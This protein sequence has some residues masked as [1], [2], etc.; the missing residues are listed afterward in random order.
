MEVNIGGPR[1]FFFLLFLSSYACN[2]G[3]SPC[4]HPCTCTCMSLACCSRWRSCRSGS[5]LKSTH[6]HLK[7]NGSKT[8]S[9]GAPMKRLRLN[10]GKSKAKWFSTRGSTLQVLW[11]AG[12]KVAKLDDCLFVFYLPAIKKNEKRNKV[13][14][15]ANL[16]IQAID[17]F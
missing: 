4:S 6:P 1:F 13:H 8:F 9:R 15:R 7:E 14:H 17:V 10:R 11:A 5:V 16:L 2:R 12:I 3:P